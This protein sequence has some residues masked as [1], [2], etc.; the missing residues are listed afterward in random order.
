LV[1]TWDIVDNVLSKVSGTAVVD[2]PMKGVTVT[3]AAEGSF[4][5]KTS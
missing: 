4:N 5:L 2:E 3:T 1:N